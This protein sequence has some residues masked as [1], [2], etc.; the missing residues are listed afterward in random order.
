[1]GLVIVW[2]ECE[3]MFKHNLDGKSRLNLKRLQDVR[4]KRVVAQV[5]QTDHYAL[6]LGIQVDLTVEWDL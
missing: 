1:M 3:V 6:C 4:V 5:S 2:K